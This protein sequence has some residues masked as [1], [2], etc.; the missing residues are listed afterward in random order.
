M[1]DTWPPVYQMKSGNLRGAAMLPPDV[2]RTAQV[3]ARVDAPGDGQQAHQAEDDIYS[4]EL[5]AE[6]RRVEA[7]EYRGD[8]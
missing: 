3:D 7:V 4:V 6:E 8:Q 5:N 2:H 1:P